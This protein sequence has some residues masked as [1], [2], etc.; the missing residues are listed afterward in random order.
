MLLTSFALAT[1]F[2]SRSPD[3]K[4]CFD[5]VMWWV[6]FFQS[7][8]EWKDFRVP[9]IWNIFQLCPSLVKKSFE[10]HKVN[11]IPTDWFP[12]F[13]FARIKIQIFKLEMTWKD[14][15]QACIKSSVFKIIWHESSCCMVSKKCYSKEICDFGGIKWSQWSL[16]HGMTSHAITAE[17]RLKFQKQDQ[18]VW[19]KLK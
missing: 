14:L 12:D 4:T 9:V 10:F 13:Y 18:V 15:C 2:I 6:I 19:V 3:T 11:F 7:R 16:R 5:Q 17:D 1:T 8:N